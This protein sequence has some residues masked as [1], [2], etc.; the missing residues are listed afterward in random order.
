MEFWALE[1]ADDAT[2]IFFFCC[3]CLFF[4]VAAFVSLFDWIK[5]RKKK[6]SEKIELKFI[7]DF[8]PYP[9]GRARSTGD[10]S[11]EEFYE[12]V[13]QKKF[14]QAIDEDKVLSIDLDGA[15]GYAGSFLDEAFG[16]L[17]HEFGL[18]ECKKR[19]EIV[20]KE[21]RYDEDIFQSIE[22]WSVDGIHYNSPL[23]KGKELKERNY[24]TSVKNNKNGKKK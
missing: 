10:N 4:S 20:G 2:L 7:E 11:A 15:A 8:T 23:A 9:G 6:M 21:G 22:E 19:L 17:G 12:D 18:E 14:K 16:R 24:F 3:I 1:N 13:L 5:N